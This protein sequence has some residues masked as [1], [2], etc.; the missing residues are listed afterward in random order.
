MGGELESEA[1]R[2]A[3]NTKLMRKLERKFKEAQYANDEDK[4]NLT[5][6]QDSLDKLNSK[7]KSYR[8]T[9]EDATELL[10]SPCLSSESSSTNLMKLMSAQ[11]WLKLLS[12]RLDLKPKESKSLYCYLY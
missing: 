2:T 4:K 1:R 6:L 7:A 9:A 3:D 5:R 11:K 12:T 10:I 8:K